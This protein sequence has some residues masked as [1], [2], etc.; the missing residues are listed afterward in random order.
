MT[1]TCAPPVPGFA[2]LGVTE[3]TGVSLVCTGV[4]V[5][6]VELNETALLNPPLP[7]SERFAVDDPP[8]FTG[9]NCEIAIKVKLCPCA[10][11]AD[12]AEK[13]ATNKAKK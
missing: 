4:T 6:G 3:H 1:D 7:C 13:T 2:E 8:G 5:Q 11:P 12:A 9:F 10:R